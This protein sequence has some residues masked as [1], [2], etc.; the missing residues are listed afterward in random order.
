MKRRLLVRDTGVACLQG[1]VELIG[2]AGESL[3][4]EL[5]NSIRRWFDQL[6]VNG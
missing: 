4:D 5:T 3:I 1:T 2:D 6:M